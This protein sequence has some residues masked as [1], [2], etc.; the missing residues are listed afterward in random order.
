[1]KHI[2][3]IVHGNEFMII[4]PHANLY[5][6]EI[7]LRGGYDP[8][9]STD[10]S[11]KIYD[12][13]TTFPIF[14]T[15]VKWQ[16]I[17]IEEAHHLASALKWL[18]EDLKI[19]GSFD[20]YLA[21]MDLKPANIL[22]V[23]DSRSPAGKWMLSDFGVSSFHKAT[24][25]RAPDTPSIRDVSYR[26]TSPGFQH[27]IVRGHGPYQPPEVDLQNVDSR[28]CD[29]WS[30]AGIL[31]DILAFLI[32]KAAA[33]EDLRSSRYVT[34]DD[35]FYKTVT[36]TGDTIREIDDSNTELKPQIVD[37]WEKLERSSVTW[38]VDYIRV[39]RDAL[40]PKPSDRS[41]IQDIVYGLNALA[42]LIT[43]QENGTI[44]PESK[45]PSSKPQTNPHPSQ[46]G[47]PFITFSPSPSHYE[48]MDHQDTASKFGNN[49]Q[50]LS[51]L[52]SPGPALHPDRAL[53][54][55]HEENSNQNSS[56]T[57]DLSKSTLTLPIPRSP[58]PP[59]ELCPKVHARSVSILALEERPKISI[60]LP[61]RDK[62]K[63]VSI[64]PSLLQVAVLCKHSV[65]F[66]SKI[67]RPGMRRQIDLSPKVDWKKIRL[68]S[69]YFAVYGLKLPHEKQ[70]S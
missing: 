34:G 32:G 54:A 61:K 5:N 57:G 4:L 56:S 60:P 70:V 30:F 44:T 37:W 51:K 18:H 47:T 58:S 68:A 23:G 36:P 62:V 11:R 17:L 63:A 31:C 40:R 65:H 2:A 27:T 53:P 9:P 14:N 16:H 55:K 26:L 42:P 15:S 8:D 13:K 19:F 3:A 67:D 25:K 10:Y 69:Q 45:V 41:H 64:T 12:F 43:S 20:R 7:F 48:T 6:L 52:L 28:K 46:E 24:N 50:S 66:Y 22:L 49:D 21:H 38:V 35:Y 59:E 29:V 39:L 1:M 33:V